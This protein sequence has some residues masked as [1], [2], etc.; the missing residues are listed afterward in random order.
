MIDER[1]CGRCPLGPKPLERPEC[2]RCEADMMGVEARK[3]ALIPFRS[4]LIFDGVDM[5]ACFEYELLPSL[6]PPG[7]PARERTGLLPS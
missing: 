6:L 5:T 4:A 2:N 1:I 7:D 3:S